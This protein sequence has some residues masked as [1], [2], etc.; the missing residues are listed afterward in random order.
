ME[1]GINITITKEGMA[2]LFWTC[3]TSGSIGYGAL[4]LDCE[5]EVYT[6][7]RERLLDRNPNEM[8][9][10]EDVYKEVLLNDGYILVNEYDEYDDTNSNIARMCLDDLVDNFKDVEPS[11]ILD[12]VNG[13]DDMCTHD[14]ILQ[15]LFLG[16][17][18][19][20]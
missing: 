18:V 11:L 16:E 6:W 20:G 1:Y 4:S 2:D 5:K 14:E 10:Y 15:C 8:V 7:A 13:N 17:V 19:Y 9:C 3:I 12:M